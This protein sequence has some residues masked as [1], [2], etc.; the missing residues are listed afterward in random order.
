[1]L[2]SALW[3]ALGAVVGLVVGMV[4]TAVFYTKLAC[5]GYKEIL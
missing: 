1:M 5:A 3:F 2:E 4:G